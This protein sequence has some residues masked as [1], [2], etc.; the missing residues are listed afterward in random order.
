M[1][2]FAIDLYKNLYS[3]NIPHALRGEKEPRTTV[4]AQ[5]K[6]LPAETE[7]IVKM[8]EET[9]RQMQ[10]IRDGQ[11]LFDYLADKCVFRV[12]YLDTIYKA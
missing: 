1:A 4:A 9:A 12:V 3:D 7:P 10:S 2:D 5:V 6:Q 8:F 11:M